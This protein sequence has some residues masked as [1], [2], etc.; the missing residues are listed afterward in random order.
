MGGKVKHPP[1][2]HFSTPLNIPPP[3]CKYWIWQKMSGLLPTISQKHL[4][5]YGSKIAMS[6]L[7]LLLCAPAQWIFSSWLQESPSPQCFPNV[8]LR[9]RCRGKEVQGSAGRG[10]NDWNWDCPSCMR[11]SVFGSHYG[12]RFQ[13]LA[14]KPVSTHRST[15]LSDY[16]ASHKLRQLPAI[17]DLGPLQTTAKKHWNHHSYGHIEITVLQCFIRVPP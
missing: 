1:S 12:N 2:C 8:P 14:E 13:P 7:A 15:P 16:V 5:E 3:T 10:K 17:H 11:E 4:V 6:R 9:I